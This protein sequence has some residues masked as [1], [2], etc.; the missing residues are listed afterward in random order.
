MQIPLLD[1]KQQFEAIQDEIMPSLAKLCASQQFILGPKVE[2]VERRIA[3]YCQAA[4]GCGVT[5][6]SD[7]LLV[8]LMAEQIGAGDEVITSPYTFFATAGAICRTGAKPVFVDIDP[9]TYNIDVTQIEAAITPKTRAIIPVHLYGQAADM[10]AILA[11]A[12][13][14][15]LVVVEDACQAIGAECRGRRVGALGEYGCLSF[16]PSKNLG[17]FGDGGMVLANDEKRAARLKI[18]RNHGMAPQY[19][20]HLIGSNFRLDALQAE[21]LLKKLPHLDDWTAARQKNA[22]DYDRLFAGVDGIALPVEAAWSTR[23][24]R[25][26]YVIRIVNGRRD[27]IWEGLKAV[28]IGCAVYYP[29]PLHLQECFTSLGYGPGDFPESE[30][31]AL[32]TLALPIFP[33]LTMEQKERVAAE[34]IRLLKA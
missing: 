15:G 12:Q 23:H 30:R 1:L 3:E 33:E 18:L 29:V 32:E 31:A 16:F 13:K 24:V 14:H 4:Y 25:N 6:G 19:H 20:H 10:D 21:V 26:Q 27:V 17:C 7:A 11:I 2:E 8:S 34:V 9:V 28:G 22:A 5:S